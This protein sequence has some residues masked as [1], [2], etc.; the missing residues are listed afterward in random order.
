MIESYI[1]VRN[2]AS[3]EVTIQKSRFIGHAAPCASEE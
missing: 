2:Q 3:D 1:T